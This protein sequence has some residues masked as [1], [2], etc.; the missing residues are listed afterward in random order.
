MDRGM[1][2]RSHPLMQ[3]RGVSNWPPTWVQAISP[4]E[5]KK[6]R[7]EIGVLNEVGSPRSISLMTACHITIEYE[8]ERYVGTLL[9]DDP[10]FCFLISKVLSNHLGW[11][12]ED[13]G[14][15]DLS[16]AL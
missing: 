2:L 3:Y 14:S 12:I 1:E 16:F 5:N 10:A 13:I 6:L 15:I 4:M 9:F 8:L 11:S 7:G